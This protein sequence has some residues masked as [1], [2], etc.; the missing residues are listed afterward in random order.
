MKK[1]MKA[2]AAPAAPKAAAT[3]ESMAAMKQVMQAAAAPAA[4]TALKKAMEPT[5]A[6]SAFASASPPPGSNTP[7]VIGCS[8]NR[9]IRPAKNATTSDATTPEKKA[10]KRRQQTAEVPGADLGGWVYPDLVMG[11]GHSGEGFH[12]EGIDYNIVEECWTAEEQAVADA[13]VRATPSHGWIGD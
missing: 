8:A 6:A 3:P 5:D 7:Q 1:V 9:K 12:V 2:A 4:A 10:A 13:F 11:V